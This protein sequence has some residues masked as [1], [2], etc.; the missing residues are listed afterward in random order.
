M[1]QPVQP[2]LSSGHFFGATSIETD[3]LCEKIYLVK[4][5]KANHVATTVQRIQRDLKEADIESDDS[6]S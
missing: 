5:S 6:A 3:R 2:P 1:T 4:K